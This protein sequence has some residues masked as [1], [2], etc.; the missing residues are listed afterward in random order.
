MNYTK[1]LKLDLG[2]IRK[3]ASPKKLPGYV[4]INLSTV[5]L[6]KK[7]FFCLKV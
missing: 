1:G 3:N 6:S 7:V 2:L 5:A 4:Y